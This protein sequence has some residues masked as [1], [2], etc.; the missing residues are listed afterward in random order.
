MPQTSGL[1]CVCR[2]ITVRG[3]RCLDGKH[4]K[5]IQVIH[6]VTECQNMG[7]HYWLLDK[8]QQQAP[9][10]VG[11]RGDTNIWSDVFILDDFTHADIHIN[12]S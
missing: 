5:G 3:C 1:D 2:P 11:S 10:I 7:R 8:E 9:T 4:F 12:I 6:H